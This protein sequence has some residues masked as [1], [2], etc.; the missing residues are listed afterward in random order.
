MQ[1]QSDKHVRCI[2]VYLERTIVKHEWGSCLKTFV[3]ITYLLIHLMRT[4]LAAGCR[5]LRWDRGLAKVEGVHRR[6][7][8]CWRPYRAFRNQMRNVMASMQQNITVHVRAKR[9]NWHG[10]FAKWTA[11]NP[12]LNRPTATLQVMNKWLHL[13]SR[14]MK[15]KS[16]K[17]ILVIIS[18]MKCCSRNTWIYSSR[19]V[20][21]NEEPRCELA[22][23]WN[24]P[25]SI[26][27]RN[28]NVVAGC[29][30]KNKIYR[31]ATKTF[32]STPNDRKCI[33]GV[34]DAG[35][36]CLQ[37]SLASLRTWNT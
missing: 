1:I 30:T 3:R 21:K 8:G 35:I 26:P 11:W 6:E 25:H 4:L 15:K 31:S 27:A 20:K 32:F 36:I 14:E 28:G 13:A 16:R 23:G 34:R 17:E 29:E 5:W 2:C 10:K 24:V 22:N 33:Y 19:P 18:R 12:H 37:S 9:I 7:L